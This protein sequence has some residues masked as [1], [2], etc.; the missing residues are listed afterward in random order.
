[1]L[2]AKLSVGDLISQEAVY[3]AKC[4]VSLY[5]K[6]SRYVPKNVEESEDNRIHGIVLAELITFI[7][8]S[9]TATETVPVFKLADLA[10]MYT[11]RLGQL[12]VD[13]GRLK[14]TNLEN[15]T[16][17][18]SQIWKHTTWLGYL[19]YFQNRSWRS[20]KTNCKA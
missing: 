12:G 5:R 3:H 15:R 18:S 6:A 2:L 17:A 7:E 4:L 8:E 9:Q 13:A 16:L 11:R 10:K 20:S 1:M 19:T 14:T